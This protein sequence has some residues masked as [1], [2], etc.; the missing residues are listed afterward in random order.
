MLRERLKA[1]GLSG[2]PARDPV[3]VVERILA[4]QAQDARAARLA[5][6]VRSHG[7][8]AAAV[9]RALTE[10][11]SLVVGWLNRG[12]LHL[13]RSEDWGWLHALT[14]HRQ[15]NSNRRRLAEEGVS[16]ASIE[17]GV[18]TIR[19]ALAAEG[20]LTRPALKERLDSADVPTAGQA[21]LHLL[22]RAT[23]EC[24]IL[25][26]PMI[27][28]KQA[29][30][31]AEDWLGPQ[32]AVD[33][34][35]ALA[36]LAR[37]YLI[38]HGPATDRDL[39]KWAGLPLGQARTGLKQIASELREEPTGQVSLAKT[40]AG[41]ADE[42]SAPPPLPSPRLLGAFDPVLHGWA[43]RDFLIP[44]ARERKVVT[45]NGI[46]RP[47]M[48]VEGQ[49]VGTWTMPRAGVELRPFGRIN[50]ETEAALKAEADA[51]ERY[52]AT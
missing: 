3:E 40:S 13:V 37:R 21:L 23:I 41:I 17:R 20:P 29:F 18:E 28:G 4:I 19:R 38:G 14:A 44:G 2:V 35:S 47:T 22:F 34:E 50:R 45:I 48:L 10:E 27:G 8:T 5:L 36:E 52:L 6:R 7:F 51:V 32:R 49:V 16:P 30:M 12:T 11:R 1:Q 31:L 39:A 46:F 42:R 26:G 9:D 15:A 43:S 24:D 25:R 33:R